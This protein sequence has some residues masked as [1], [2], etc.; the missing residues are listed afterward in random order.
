MMVFFQYAAWILAALAAVC[1]FC[2][3]YMFSMPGRAVPVEYVNARGDT[4][5]QT[6]AAPVAG[7]ALADELDALALRLR[8]HVDVLALEIG[9]RHVSHGTARLN[10]TAEYIRHGFEACGH[11]VAELQYGDGVQQFRNVCVELPGMIRPG[12]IIVVGAHYDTVADSPGADD[13]SSGIAAL[14]ELARMLKGVPLGRTIRL[15]AFPNEEHPLGTSAMSGSVVSAKESRIQNEHITGMFSLEMLGYYSDAPHSQQFPK[16]VP[17]GFPDAGNFIAFLGNIRSRRLLRKALRSFR[18]QNIFPSEGLAVPEMLIP[19]VARSDNRSYWRAGF[20]AVMITDTA[21]FRNPHYHKD[22]DLP[23]T[24]DYAAYA[25]V[26]MG[27]GGMF[28]ALA[29]A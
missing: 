3:W 14:L 27:L 12:E 28:K 24:L 6:N 19:G 10:H 5:S 22:S 4:G 21:E 11:T 25:R 13:N 16:Y 2:F 26:V 20:R 29:N 23:A 18:E 17:P 1:G 8:A 9:A 15:I 7:M